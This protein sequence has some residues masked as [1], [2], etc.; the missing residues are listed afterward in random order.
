MPEPVGLYRSDSKRPDGAS[1]VPWRGEVLMWD[2]TCLD[3]LAPSHLSMIV[4]EAGAV[5]DDAK[6]RKKLKYSHLFSIH[7]FTAVAVESLGVFGQDARAF[8]REEARRVGSVTDDSQAHQYLVQRVSVAI[9]RCN[10]AAGL[11]C[12]GGVD[13]FFIFL[14]YILFLFFVLLLNI[15]CIVYKYNYI[16]YLLI[17]FNLNIYFLL[18]YYFIIIFVYTFYYCCFHSLLLLFCLL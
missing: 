10:A 1:V 7:C 15:V 3:T 14:L 4:R 17:N 8:F 13:Y 9:Q 12:I 18:Y 5:A 6:Y 2:A 11:G 16:K